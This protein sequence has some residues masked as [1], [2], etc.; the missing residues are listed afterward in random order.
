MTGTLIIF[1]QS[2]KDKYSFVPNA[3]GE[4]CLIHYGP[5]SCMW[6]VKSFLFRFQMIGMQQCFSWLCC[7]RL[8]ELNRQFLTDFVKSLRA[9]ISFFRN[10]I[11]LVEL[12]GAFT[13]S[14]PSA[15]LELLSSLFQMNCRCPCQDLD[16]K[17]SARLLLNKRTRF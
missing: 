4:Q 13:W 15:V 17:F 3:D 8:T 12:G 14:F 11:N 6:L 7:K 2:L 1:S 9:S 16:A 10:Y 5:G